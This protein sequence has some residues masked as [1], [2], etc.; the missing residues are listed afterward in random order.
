MFHQLEYELAHNGTQLTISSD[1]QQLN[2]NSVHGHRSLS[3]TR[4]YINKHYG[5]YVTTR[6]AKGY[7]KNPL[8]IPGC[9]LHAWSIEIL[10][11]HQLLIHL[12]LTNGKKRHQYSRV[13]TLLNGRIDYEE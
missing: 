4:E 3:Y 5:L 2:C 10:N 11:P 12:E 13:L 6:N 9:D 1:G 7:S 8:F